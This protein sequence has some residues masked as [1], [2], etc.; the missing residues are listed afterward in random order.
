MSWAGKAGSA[1]VDMGAPLGNGQ[2]VTNTGGNK[3]AAEVTGYSIMQAESIDALKG[4]LKDHPHFMS[5]GKSSIV[6]LEC[7]PMPA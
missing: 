6:V 5:P 2:T 1:I 3:G 4:L 7:L